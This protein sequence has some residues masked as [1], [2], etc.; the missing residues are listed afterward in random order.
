MEG[1][2]NE[3][4]S[5]KSTKG[6]WKQIN[7]EAKTMGA[8]E[9]GSMEEGPKRKLLPPHGEADLNKLQDKRAKLDT[10]V[11]LGKVFKKLLGL[12]EVAMQP[13]RGQ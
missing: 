7:R 3:G 13:R 9:G 10:E 6:T 2:E 5:L 4:F 12:A 11:V 1:K 8:M